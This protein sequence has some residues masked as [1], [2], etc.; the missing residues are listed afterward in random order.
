MIDFILNTVLWT[1]AIYGLIEILKTIYYIITYTNLK[2]DGA[3]LILAVKNQEDKIE[4][5]LRSILFKY[6]YGKE[7]MITDI[8]V[9]DL[10]STDNTVDILLKISEDYDNIKIMN[11]KECKELMDVY[12]KK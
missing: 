5:I 4:G 12:K 8:I 1:L 6:I 10:D 3:Y 11:W 7:E 2:Q 9:T